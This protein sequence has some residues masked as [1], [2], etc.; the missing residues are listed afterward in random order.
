LA[1]G[2][3][4]FTHTDIGHAGAV[5]DAAL[6]A[7]FTLVDVADVYGFDWG[8]RG[9]GTVE[10][11]LG[12]V[13]RADPSRRSRM[14]LATKGGIVPG[15]PYDSS[16][17]ALRHACEASLRRLGVDQIDLYQV[18]RPDVF[19][20]PHEVASALA[21]LVQ[22]GVVRCVGISNHT[23]SQH[24]ALAHEL[25]ALGVPLAATQPEF[26][27]VHL[28]PLH[29]GTL[30][31]A[32]RDRVVPLA[33]SPLAGGRI[34]TGDGVRPELLAV[35]DELAER[36]GVDRS[37]IAVAFVLSHPSRP[38]ALIGSQH[39]DR[40]TAAGRALGVQLDRTDLYRLIEASQGV[41]L[42]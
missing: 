2:T 30:D 39:P 25:A 29:D 14:V 26:S 35:L 9:F 36:E 38:V 8:G 23:V 34:A 31:R 21:A 27:V 41:P 22:A 16:A 4:R 5:L 40:L 18:H 17:T 11:L 20:H 28:D 12:S 7:G 1:F 32:L 6:D 19:A 3:W 10:E 33:W 42:P 15:V 13:L 37:A 24:D